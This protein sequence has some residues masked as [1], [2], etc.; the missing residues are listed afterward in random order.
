MAGHPRI[1]E[2]AVSES[3]E[4]L[5][6]GGAVLVPDPPS[7]VMKELECVRA[8]DQDPEIDLP[9]QAD[10]DSEGDLPTP[11]DQDS[12]SEV[13]LRMH[14]VPQATVRL[15]S[16]EER[17]RLEAVVRKMH[18]RRTLRR[19]RHGWTAQSPRMGHSPQKR[20]LVLPRLSG[21]RSVVIAIA[22]ASR[23]P[24]CEKR[25]RPGPL[26]SV[27]PPVPQAQSEQGQQPIQP[28][29]PWLGLGSSTSA[30]PS[31]VGPS[32]A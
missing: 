28:R 3:G 4:L 26:R 8:T 22:K 23:C 20:F 21:A 5:A 29:V 1:Y 19:R 16:Q 6:T 14:L 18:D 7:S 27:G 15:V 32:A 13:N 25:H 11:V 12:E 2:P 17:P 30:M 10:P 24:L 9:T 31:A